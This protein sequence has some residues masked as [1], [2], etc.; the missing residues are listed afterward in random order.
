MNKKWTI[1]IFAAIFVLANVATFLFAH[2]KIKI[3]EKIVTVYKDVVGK[4]NPVPTNSAAA[5]VD[6]AEKTKEAAK[7]ALRDFNDADYLGNDE[8]RADLS[9]KTGALDKE[10]NTAKLTDKDPTADSPKSSGTM[11]AEG[12]EPSID[13][14]GPASCIPSEPVQPPFADESI[15]MPQLPLFDTDFEADVDVGGTE[16]IPLP[17]LPDISEV[18]DDEYAES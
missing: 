17:Q 3:V 6:S 8:K 12:Q 2:G 9:V 16:N 11:K 15:P 1:I 14:Q 13:R 7:A 4:D 5:K 10:D 18:I